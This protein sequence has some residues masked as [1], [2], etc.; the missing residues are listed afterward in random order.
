MSR[1][2]SIGALLLLK[3]GNAAKQMLQ[4]QMFPFALQSCLSPQFRIEG[5]TK[6]SFCMLVR[7][8][9]LFSLFFNLLSL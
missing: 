5:E 6:L 7:K 3:K 8:I 4:M 2:C 1:N 9:V